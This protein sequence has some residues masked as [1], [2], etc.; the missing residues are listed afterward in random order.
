[1]AVHSFEYRPGWPGYLQTAGGVA[2]AE[3]F[4]AGGAGAAADADFEEGAAF[5]AVVGLDERAAAIGGVLATD[6]ASGVGLEFEPLGRD[7]L[8]TDFAD[9][10]LLPVVAV[11]L[12]GIKFDSEP[13]L[14]AAIAR[15][16]LAVSGE[17]LADNLFRR[18]RGAAEVAE[19]AK[20]ADD[21]SF[22][23]KSP[24]TAVLAFEL[25]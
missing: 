1:L 4:I 11:G 15:E 22:A 25:N 12:V 10:D 19:G 7:W 2:G 21:F 24:P 9:N 14:L 3:E 13:R 23:A 18:I 8:T 16:T 5:G 20:T 17:D 6:A